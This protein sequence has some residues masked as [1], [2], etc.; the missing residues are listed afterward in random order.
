M[1]LSTLV[2]EERIR[3]V[4]KRAE[5]VSRTL[6]WS[7]WW[8]KTTVTLC[9][10]SWWTSYPI[11]SPK[12][13]STCLASGVIKEAKNSSVQSSAAHRFPALF[14]AS[15]VNVTCRCRICQWHNCFSELAIYSPRNPT[16]CLQSAIVVKSWPTKALASWIRRCVDLCAVFRLIV[17]LFVCCVLL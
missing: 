13:Q 6:E 9:W 16:L 10:L 12:L 7:A 15:L 1:H 2:S 4:F 17:V 3:A 14:T 5:M 11:A 8:L